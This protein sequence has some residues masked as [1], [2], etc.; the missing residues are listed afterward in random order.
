MSDSIEK[1]GLCCFNEFEKMFF[2]T[3]ILCLFCL[4]ICVC[5]HKNVPIC[6]TLKKIIKTNILMYFMSMCLSVRLTA[7]LSPGNKCFLCLCAFCFPLLKRRSLCLVGIE[8]SKTHGLYSLSVR[9]RRTNFFI[10][11]KETMQKAH[12]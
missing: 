6:G 10:N 9:L 4:C 12:Q 5:F 7:C 8:L 2:V 1:R 11:S 3:R